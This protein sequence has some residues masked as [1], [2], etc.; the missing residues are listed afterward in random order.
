VISSGVLERFVAVVLEEGVAAGTAQ[1]MCANTLRSWAVGGKNH[2]GEELRR[3]VREAARVAIAG[4]EKE[5]RGNLAEAQQRIAKLEASGVRVDGHVQEKIGG[6]L[7]HR[8]ALAEGLRSSFRTPIGRPTALKFLGR[9][10]AADDEIAQAL[11][12]IAE[13]DGLLS[14]A[15]GYAR[16]TGPGQKAGTFHGMH[17]VQRAT[18]HKSMRKGKG[19]VA[20]SHCGARVDP[21]ATVCP[22]CQKPPTSPEVTADASPRAGSTLVEAPAMR[23][24]ARTG[25][26]KTK[27]KPDVLGGPDGKPISADTD[28]NKLHPRQRGGPGGGR[29]IQ[30]GDGQDDS[31][32]RSMLRRRSRGLRSWG[33][34]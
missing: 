23:A 13:V 6:Q 9:A 7:Q 27:P 28:F 18:R 1:A 20:C 8:A 33:I 24:G 22:N 19:T 15:M 34:R 31:W 14:E 4:H 10:D 2:R 32:R 21:D 29:F 3:E 26:G 30:K 25:R 5:L 12:V 11:A 17:G 16:A